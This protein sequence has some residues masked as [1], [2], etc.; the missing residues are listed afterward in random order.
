MRACRDATRK[1][2]AR[3][4]L[5]LVMEVKESKKGFQYQKGDDGKVGP[6]LDE[7]DD[8]K[9]ED[10]EKEE[11][12]NAFFASVFTANTASQKSQNM[13][14]RDTVWRTKAIPLFE[15]DLVRDHL[16]KL[17]TWRYLA[18]RRDG[19][20]GNILTLLQLRGSCAEDEVRLFSVVPS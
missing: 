4:E 5:N 13:E 19:S 1:S 14:V 8:L 16:G 9:M 15:E 11:L 10:T 17:N 6:L 12:L 20:E 2:E 18:C 7:V 3:L